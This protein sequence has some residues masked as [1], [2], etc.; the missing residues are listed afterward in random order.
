VWLPWFPR[1]RV[2]A[3]FAPWSA[4]TLWWENGAVW[5]TQIWQVTKKELEK[6]WKPMERH[7]NSVD[8]HGPYGNF[9]IFA[10]VMVGPMLYVENS[11]CRCWKENGEP[12]KDK[13]LRIDL[14]TRHPSCVTSCFYSSLRRRTKQNS[15]WWLKNSTEVW[16][17]NS[18]LISHDIPLISHDIPLIV[19]CTPQFPTEIWSTGNS[20]A[21]K[22]CTNVEDEPSRCD[23]VFSQSHD[24]DDP[25]DFAPFPISPYRIPTGNI[26]IS[27]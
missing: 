11:P 4:S 10:H 15:D 1:L 18:P 8:P 9:P 14:G 25:W 20:E 17:S 26:S 6:A 24:W 22:T 2:G 3:V 23:A 16:L 12:G 27:Q 7:R 5:A 13:P 21:C 19:A